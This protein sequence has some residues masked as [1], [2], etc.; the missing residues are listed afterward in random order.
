[1]GRSFH[2]VESCRMLNGTSRLMDHHHY[3][4][5]AH[6]TILNDERASHQEL[7]MF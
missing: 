3:V 1:M 7:G 2:R 6:G 5:I 4:Q